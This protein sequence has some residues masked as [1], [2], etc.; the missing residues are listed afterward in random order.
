MTRR[1]GSGIGIIDEVVDDAKSV[2]GVSATLGALAAIEHRKKKA[3][4][5]RLY[6]NE[7]LS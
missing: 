2:A 4:K 7:I 1:F 6:I 3:L 5:D